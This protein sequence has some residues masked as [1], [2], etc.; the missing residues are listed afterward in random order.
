MRIVLALLAVAAHIGFAAQTDITEPF[1]KIE[2]RAGGTVLVEYGSTPRATL[3]DPASNT[4]RISVQAGTLRV[5]CIEPCREKGPQTVRVTVPS[6]SS[7]SV[8]AGGEVKI[9]KGF[10]RTR[11]LAVHVS[12]GGTIDAAALE[13]DSVTAEV[14]AGGA[15]TVSARDHLKSRVTAGGR[16][17]YYGN[18]QLDTKTFAGGDVRRLGAVASR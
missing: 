4:R 1:D 8:S 2:V 9:G 12:A 18:P 3:V 5:T 16:V 10:A 11:A 7:I 17:N 15:A 6:L 14:T 13:A